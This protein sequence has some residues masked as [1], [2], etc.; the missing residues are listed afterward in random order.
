MHL[1]LDSTSGAPRAVMCGSE[2][3]EELDEANGS[4]GEV[5]TQILIFS[6]KSRTKL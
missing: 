5:G 1:C 2:R 6:I 4:G 3:T